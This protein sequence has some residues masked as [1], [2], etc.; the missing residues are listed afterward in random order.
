MDSKTPQID[1]EKRAIEISKVFAKKAY[2]LVN[3]E[4]EERFFFEFSKRIANR[5][6]KLAEAIKSGDAEVITLNKEALERMLDQVEPLAKVFGLEK[7]QEWLNIAKEAASGVLSIALK[8]T[9]G[10]G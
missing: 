10:L 9:L 4:A 5:E 6:Y 2:N 3:S 7:S 1:I 8:A